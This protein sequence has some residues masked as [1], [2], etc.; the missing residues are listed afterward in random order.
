MAIYSN[1]QV[2]WFSGIQP[3]SSLLT[4]LY[5]VYNADGNTNDSF[6]TRNG[7]AQGGLTYTTGKIGQAFQ[8][9]ATN[10][11]VRIPKTD[12]EFEFTGDF[13]ISCWFNQP[14]G[15]NIFN[16]YY[17]T[18]TTNRYGYNLYLQGGRVRFATFKGNTGAV[19]ASNIGQAGRVI[20]ANTW[21]HVVVTKKVGNV[22]K[23]YINNILQTI[24]VIDG[25]LSLTPVYSPLTTINIGAEQATSGFF[26]GKIDALTTW[27]KELTTTEITELYNSGNGKQYPF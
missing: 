2:G 8:F 19:S 18:S 7:T 17:S 25:D 16:N 4:N 21:Y 12:N 15:G 23:I 22:F 5:S 10:A 3:P 9:N 26:S 6:G 20:A 24:T 14:T 27:T 13:S 11:Y 1:G